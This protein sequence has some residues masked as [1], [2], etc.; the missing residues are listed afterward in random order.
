VADSRKAILVLTDGVDETLLRDDE[1][2]ART[3]H[4]FA[5]LVERVQ[6]EEA[7]IYPI[8][9]NPVEHQLLRL[10]EDNLL[11]EGRRARVE[12]RLKPNLIAHRQIDQLADETAGTVFVA[13]GER[14]L[15][16]VYQR[17]AAELRM[18]YT[19]SYSPKRASRDGKFRKIDVT[20]GREGAVV[21]TRRGY[22]AR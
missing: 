9:L 1:D 17:V 2:E 4:T 6:E 22:I 3:T 11:S 10:L 12:R 20:V 19:L 18:I 5:E 8:Y 16:G 21:K 7:T 15:D 13:E 14:E